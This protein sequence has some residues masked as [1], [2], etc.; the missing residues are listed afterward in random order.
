MTN[1][2]F[3]D[4]YA[5]VYSGKVD[6]WRPYGIYLDTF[7]LNPY[8]YIKAHVYIFLASIIVWL[9]YPIRKLLPNHLTLAYVFVG[10][11]S[12]GCYYFWG[13]DLL[14]LVLVNFVFVK[15]AL[16]WA[17]GSLARLK[18]QTSSLGD[19]MDRFGAAV[20]SWA[21]FVF[22]LLFLVRNNGITWE[23]CSVILVVYIFA[24]ALD[25][26]EFGV[27]RGIAKASSPGGMASTGEAGWA[28]RAR[29]LL[30]F[31]IDDRARTVDLFALIVLLCW[32]DVLNIHVLTSLVLAQ[33]AVFLSRNVIGA[34]RASRSL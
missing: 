23:I 5:S 16:D 15:G 9:A 26:R 12:V 34:Y 19:W 25:F 8:T 29:E 10:P 24:R 17:D 33:T 4:A 18:R 7:Y 22:L 1:I 2:K 28:R 30:T 20:N 13:N 27:L 31:V 32:I 21:F 11:L 6:F 14:F 3:A